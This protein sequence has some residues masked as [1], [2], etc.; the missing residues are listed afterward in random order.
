MAEAQVNLDVTRRQV[1]GRDQVSLQ[2]RI[3]A[4]IVGR[5]L[6]VVFTLNE[7]GGFDQILAT[8][9]ERGDEANL[10]QAVIDDSEEDDSDDDDDS[11]DLISDD[12]ES[13]DGPTEAVDSRVQPMAHQ[14]RRR[15]RPSRV[16][17]HGPAGQIAPYE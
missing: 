11:E 4:A 12:D 5:P 3:P 13:T 16:S 10:P 15:T 9:R 8:V 6:V 2:M 17:V 14:P 1:D 7:E